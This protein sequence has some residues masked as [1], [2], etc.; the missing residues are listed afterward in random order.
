MPTIANGIVFTAYPSPQGRPVQPENA[1]P[2]AN[3][4]PVPNAESDAAP[5]PAAVNGT[6]VLIAIDLH[7]GRILW[8]RWVDG[9]VILTRRSEREGEQAAESMANLGV[10]RLIQSKEYNKKNAPYLDKRV[11][12]DSNLKKKSADFDAGNGFS[13]GA[14]ASSG[15][16]AANEVVGQSN[17]SS[18]QS[19]Q[20][21][22]APVYKGAAFNT[23]GD[24][25]VSTNPATGRTNWKMKI[26]GDLA[27][28]GGFIGAPPLAAGD[29]IVLAG[30]NGEISIHDPATGMT[31]KTYAVAGRIRYQ[32]VIQ[33]GWIYVTTDDG[34]LIAVNTGDIILTGWNMWGGNAARTNKAE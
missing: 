32:P 14:P 19:F 11:Q 17:V 24:E 2:L 8:Q 10:A 7:T 1:A 29:R 6:H 15:W 34:K 21:S 18:L 22:R 4:A 9:D 26:S 20:G 28:E 16:E 23:M 3:Q 30:Y 12:A 25:L 33:D 27:R 31:L 13:G 5:P